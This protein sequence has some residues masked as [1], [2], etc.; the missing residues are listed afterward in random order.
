M[1]DVPHQI[2]PV[3]GAQRSIG[4]RNYSAGEGGPAEGRPLLLLLCSSLIPPP[5]PSSPLPPFSSSSL[6]PSLPFYPLLHSPSL[7]SPSGS[8][9]LNAVW[10]EP[11]LKFK[12]SW[13]T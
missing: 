10:G 4:T 9:S 2:P 1:R 5:P 11:T 7:S 8:F 12:P 6:L 3:Q 13:N